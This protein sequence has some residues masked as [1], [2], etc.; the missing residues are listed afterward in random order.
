MFQPQPGRHA[1]APAD[2]L[3][4][5]WAVPLETVVKTL[6]KST[7]CQAGLNLGAN[8]GLWCMVSTGLSRAGP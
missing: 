3:I 2:V 7:L 5:R 1:A 6:R 8:L 4:C